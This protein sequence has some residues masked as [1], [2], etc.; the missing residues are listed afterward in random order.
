LPSH[1]EGPELLPGG[2]IEGADNWTG[3]SGS[4]TLPEACLRVI[5]GRGSPEQ[6]LRGQAIM[7]PPCEVPHLREVLKQEALAFFGI[8]SFPKRDHL[9]AGNIAWMTRNARAVARGGNSRA[10]ATKIRWRR[11]FQSRKW[12]RSGLLLNRTRDGVEVGDGA[13]GPTTAI[14]FSSCRNSH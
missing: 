2:G 3:L 13:Y 1:V 4:G 8:H 9:R 14:L 11:S 6:H 10:Y 5:C 7:N 12:N